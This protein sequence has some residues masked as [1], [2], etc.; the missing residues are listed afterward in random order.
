MCHLRYVVNSWTKQA[1]I[2]RA[3]TVHFSLSRSMMVSIFFNLI[4]S[5]FV[6]RGSYLGLDCQNVH[7]LCKLKRI[8]T[9]QMK[10][11][12]KLCLTWRDPGGLTFSYWVNFNHSHKNI[13]VSRK[14]RIKLL[15]IYCLD[16]KKGYRFIRKCRKSIYRFLWKF[17]PI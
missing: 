2:E 17:I 10:T 11:N 8:L 15:F 3:E 9:D 13:M 16:R 14:D 12:V 5:S 1:Y 7:Y 6:E 4:I